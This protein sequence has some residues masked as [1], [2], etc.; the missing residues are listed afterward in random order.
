MVLTGCVPAHTQAD[1]E[2][3]PHYLAGKSRVNAMDYKGA[4]ESFQKAL[5]VNPQSGAA[6]FELGWLYD[7]K[8][9]DPAAAIY[10]YEHYLKLRPEPDKVEMVKTRILACKQALARTVSMGPVM[11]SAQKELQQ[12]AEE[13]KQQQAELE[14][15]R[16]YVQYLERLTNA[17]AATPPRT[18]QI[19]PTGVQQVSMRSGSLL[20]RSDSVNA[21]S[22]SRL[23]TGTSSG[24][25]HTVKQGETLTMISRRYGVKIDSLIAANPKLDPK[26]L[27][28]GQSLNIPG[29]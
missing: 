20:Q 14:K 23:A 19:T 2:K 11:Q 22:S 29:S 18:G 4:V 10:H 12:L 9:S 17:A 28:V 13:K 26:R 21:G 24:R 16:A 1:D 25:T 5:E 7:Q 27:R 15:L 3:E 6:H 8:E